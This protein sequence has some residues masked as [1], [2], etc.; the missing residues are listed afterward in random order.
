M[1]RSPATAPAPRASTKT[2]GV[3]VTVEIVICERP[4]EGPATMIEVTDIGGQKAVER[5]GGQEELIECDSFPRNCRSSAGDEGHPSWD[6][7]W[8]FAGRCKLLPLLVNGGTAPP[9]G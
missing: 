9:P 1:A 6:D 8:L 3:R 5:R 4:L 2:C 7:N